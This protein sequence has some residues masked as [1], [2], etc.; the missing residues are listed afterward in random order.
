MLKPKN[1]LGSSLKPKG[2][3]KAHFLLNYISI[4]L[5]TYVLSLLLDKWR[6]TNYAYK[7]NLVCNIL[8][9]ESFEWKT[10]PNHPA[11]FTVTVVKRRNIPHGP[12]EAIIG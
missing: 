9:G 11:F 2:S 8:L 12:D 1:I 10:K 5:K 4:C 3:G 6:K 7:P